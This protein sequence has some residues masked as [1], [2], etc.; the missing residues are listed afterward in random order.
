VSQPLPLAARLRRDD[1]P[2]CRLLAAVGQNLRGLAYHN[3]NHLADMDR[4]FI[5][6]SALDGD[7]VIALATDAHRPDQAGWSLR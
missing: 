1:S 4:G 3:P 6:P 5:E 7:A 2:A